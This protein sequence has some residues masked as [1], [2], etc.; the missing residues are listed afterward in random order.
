MPATVARRNSFHI[1]SPFEKE[2]CSSSEER[3]RAGKV[4][5]RS[6]RDCLPL[7]NPSYHPSPSHLSSETLLASTPAARLLSGGTTLFYPVVARGAIRSSVRVSA[8]TPESAKT[9]SIGDTVT[10]EHLHAL[11]SR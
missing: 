11:Q 6:R 5:R 8:P 2:G 10:A 7:G 4:A 9:L 3:D 1:V